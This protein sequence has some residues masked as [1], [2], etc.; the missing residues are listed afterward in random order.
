MR[1]SSPDPGLRR[2]AAEPQ[3]VRLAFSPHSRTTT[4]LERGVAAT[5]IVLLFAGVLLVPLWQPD[6]AAAAERASG[7]LEAAAVPA[8]APRG[9]LGP[10][11]ISSS[12]ASTIP[13]TTLAV[14]A[15]TPPFDSSDRSVL[16][17]AEAGEAP[18]FDADELR[19]YRFWTF[20]LEHASRL[21]KVTNGAF[22]ADDFESPEADP[23]SHEETGPWPEALGLDGVEP[24]PDSVHR[25]PDWKTWNADPGITV[26]VIDGALH[27]RGTSTHA[28]GHNFNGFLSAPIAATDVVVIADVSCVAQD[29]DAAASTDDGREALAMVHLCG[30]SPD[31]FHEAAFEP[32]SAGGLA[33]TH[34][35]RSTGKTVARAPAS[36]ARSFRVK[37]AHDS[38]TEL[39]RAWIDAGQGWEEIGAGLTV[40]LPSV[41]LEL[42]ANLIGPGLSVD[43][44]FDNVRLYPRPEVAPVRLLAFV[45]GRG[46]AADLALDVHLGDE[47]APWMSTT[48]DRFGRARFTLPPE[49]DYPVTARFVFTTPDGISWEE[50]LVADEVRGLYPGDSLVVRLNPLELEG[51]RDWWRPY[52]DERVADGR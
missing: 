39:G 2:N 49:R 17:R 29:P 31:W 43:T 9:P 21:V 16:E 34:R 22:L 14:T 10:K 1:A 4:P 44:S 20:Y 41:K 3:P 6:D 38:A 26:G 25:T 13:G 27:V 12:L 15:F 23:A 36:P 37:L 42:K 24:W 32:A 28:S 11:S 50:T 8:G 19:R 51:E 5:T 7:L 33:W 35:A 46:D 18:S 47:A 40:P 30:T 45:G 52:Y 48:L